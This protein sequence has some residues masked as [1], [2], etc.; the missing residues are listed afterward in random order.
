MPG[1]MGLA[2]ANKGK[3]IKTI[4]IAMLIFLGWRVKF[5]KIV[6]R[7]GSCTRPQQRAGTRPAPTLE[8]LSLMGDVDN[9]VPPLDAESLHF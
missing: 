1:S 9:P 8:K 4:Q 7:G 3:S 6:R 2:E 5:R